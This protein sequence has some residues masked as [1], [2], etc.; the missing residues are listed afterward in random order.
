M[1]YL[2][3]SASLGE[4][5]ENLPQ[6]RYLKISN[7]Y[8]AIYNPCNEGDLKKIW[9]VREV[10]H[11]TLIVK[12]MVILSIDGTDIPINIHEDIYKILQDW[13]YNEYE[14]HSAIMKRCMNNI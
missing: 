7:E 9:Y 2:Y 1:G 11:A 4:I 8:V 6:A 14:S 5:V 12:N 13:Y 10:T 3:T